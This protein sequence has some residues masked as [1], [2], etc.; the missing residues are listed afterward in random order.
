MLFQLSQFFLPFIPLCPAL[1]LPP[2][3]P[4]PLSLCQQGIHISYLASPFPILFLTSPVYFV[5]TIY[6]Y[7]IYIYIYILN[8]FIVVQYTC[9]HFLPTPLPHRS[10]THLPPLLPHSPLV[11]SMCPLQQ[12][13]KTLPPTIP[14]PLPSGCCQIVLNFNVSGYILFPFFLLLYMFS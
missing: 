14:S 7:Y 10:Q 9:L 1:P 2:A 12:F 13:L 6:T 4:H 8:Y 11:L 3:F 5:P